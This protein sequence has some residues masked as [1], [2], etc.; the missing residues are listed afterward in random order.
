MASLHQRLRLNIKVG[1]QFQIYWASFQFY[2]QQWWFFLHK[3]ISL[4][5]TLDKGPRTKSLGTN[6]EP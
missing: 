3:T 1:H 4:R 2:P 5:A 6:F